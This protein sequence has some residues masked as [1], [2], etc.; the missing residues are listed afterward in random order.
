MKKVP[1]MDYKVPTM[2][3]SVPNVDI[4]ASIETVRAW[5]AEIVICVILLIRRESTYCS[6]FGLP[7][8]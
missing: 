6:P 7:N 8:V 3:N 4:C 2:D 5:F 1:T